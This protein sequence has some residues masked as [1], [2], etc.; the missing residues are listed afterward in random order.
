MYIQKFLRII[1]Q[2]LMQMRKNFRNIFI[3]EVKISAYS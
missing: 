3:Y 1:K 2:E